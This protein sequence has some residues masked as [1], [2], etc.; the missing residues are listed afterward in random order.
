MKKFWE[1]LRG[2]FKTRPTFIAFFIFAQVAS[3]ANSVTLMNDSDYMLKANLYDANGTLLGEFVLN[4]R[5]ATQW[6]DDY[7]NFGTESYYASELPYSVNWS[8]M[9]GSAFG[10]CNDVAAGAVVTAQSCGGAQQCQQQ[11]GP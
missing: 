1:I 8:C 7:L 6:S 10:S 5:E 2:C 4:P 3:W 11:Q 9:N